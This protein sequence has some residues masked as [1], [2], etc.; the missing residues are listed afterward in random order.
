MNTRTEAWVSAGNHTIARGR[1]DL[2][3]PVG[4]ELLVETLAC[5]VC[6]TDLHVIDGELPPHRSPV[7]PGH[8]VVGRIL[9]T[10]P[11]ARRLRP[12]DLVGI[13][14]LRSTCGACGYCLTGRENLCADARFTGYDADGGYARHSLV[15]EAFAYALPAGTDPVSTAP[16][17]CAGIIGYRA[18]RRANLPP[19]GHLGLYGFGSSAHLTAPLALAAGASVSAM[20]RGAANQALARRMPLRF[21]GD[22]TSRPP[23]DLD[24]AI[25]FAP[26]GALVPVALA[27][28]K[29][30]GTVVVAG[31]HISDIPAL[32]YEEHLFHER[33][34]R[35]V[36]GNTRADGQEF[37]RLAAHLRLR[38]TVTTYGFGQVAAAV[39]DLRSGRASG[40]LVIAFDR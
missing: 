6:R 12:G 28:T 17:L 26:A 36:T 33:D 2:P 35:S 34:L 11:D 16:L 27:A 18:L 9:S 39:D 3:A 10:G 19:G 31:I 7:V 32:S 15:R 38:P 13:A 20:T 22:E 40:S 4:D 24:A 14:W 23:D 37:L 29:P 8:Q 5:G 30:G 1:L 25:I 21:V